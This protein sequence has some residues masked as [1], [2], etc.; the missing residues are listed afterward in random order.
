MCIEFEIKLVFSIMYV[1]CVHTCTNYYEWYILIRTSSEVHASFVNL[2][3]SRSLDEGQGVG[4]EE[5]VRG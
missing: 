3:A 1:T 4:R 5:A 2:S